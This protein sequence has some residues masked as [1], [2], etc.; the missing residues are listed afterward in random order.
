MKILLALAFA[1]VSIPAFAAVNLSVGGLVEVVVYLLV[2][3]G[4]FWLLLWLIGYIGIP[5]PFSK[6]AKIIIM[7]VGVLILINVLLSFVGHPLVNLR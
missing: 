3:G 5:E 4:I 6:V 1:L 2:V 7:V